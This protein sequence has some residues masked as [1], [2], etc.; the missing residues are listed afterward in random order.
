M[1]NPDLT[2]A[3]NLMNI[4]QRAELAVAEQK[5]LGTTSVG[6][7]RSDPAVDQVLQQ[8]LKLAD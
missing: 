6:L 7:S 3:I 8:S 1:S 4:C 5:R 2:I